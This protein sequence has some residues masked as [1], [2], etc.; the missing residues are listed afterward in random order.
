M[1]YKIDKNSSCAVIG[2]GSW[3]TAIVKILLENENQVSWLIQNQIVKEHILD[4]GNNPKYLSDV[5]FDTTKLFISS[6]I[7][8]I[9]NSADIIILAVPSAY[10]KNTLSTVRVDLSDKFVVSAIKGILPEEL[11]TVAEYVNKELGVPFDQIGLISGPCHAE[12]VAL[13][14]LSYITVVCKSLDNAG[15]LA[16]KMRSKY[17][18]VNY[19]TD[20]YGIEYASVLKNIYAI[21]VGVAI[22]QGYGDNFLAVLISNSTSEMV[23]FLEQ[24]YPSSRDV[25]SSAYLG[26]LLVTA[27]SQFSRNRRFGVMIGKGYS[28]F[29]TQIEMNMVAEGYFATECIMRINEKFGVDMPILYAMYQILYKKA[30]VKKTMTNLTSKLI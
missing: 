13:E 10:L 29:S 8:K 14:R 4:E 28:V 20:I 6:D 5:E 9:L 18:K 2:Y 27:Y 22:G 3:A 17:I 25:T 11:I 15:L 7:N 21:A 1:V 23:R 30:S 16:S 19:S 24:T 12:E 26:D